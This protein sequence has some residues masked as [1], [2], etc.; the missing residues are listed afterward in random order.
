MKNK[1]VYKMTKE[2]LERLKEI[3]A[4]LKEL[5]GLDNE[6]ETF[7]RVQKKKA[8][9]GTRVLFEYSLKE[10]FYFIGSLFNEFTPAECDRI[11]ELLKNTEVRTDILKSFKKYMG[12][13]SL[14]NK[15]IK[16]ILLEILE[17]LFLD[18]LG[19]ENIEDKEHCKNEVENI[20]TNYSEQAQ[21][22]YLKA[23]DIYKELAYFRECEV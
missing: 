5:Y 21:R 3:K 6:R 20:K 17:D 16:N 22:E 2:Y 10:E 1:G 23:N 19:V 15:I 8:L 13:K 7:Y 14:D 11:E 4:D 9:I 18:L 12:D